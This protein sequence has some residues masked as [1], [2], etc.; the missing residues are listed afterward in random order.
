MRNNNKVAV[1]EAVF[2][3]KRF[4]GVDVLLGPEMKSTGEVMGL[5]NNFGH[6]FA[7]SQTAT[8]TSIPLEG[9][10]FISVK[11]KDKKLISEICIRLIKFGYKIVCTKGTGEFLK[12]L[13]LNVTVVNKVREGRPHIVDL[14]KNNKIGMIFN[15]TEGSKSISD[16]F[17][18]REAALLSNIPYYTTIS[19][20]NAVILAIKKLKSSK[21]SIKSLQSY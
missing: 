13:G 4:K 9:N 6:A 10:V 1:K 12:L 21:S 17:S 14:I 3:F 15:T 11:D 19:G 5:D 16:S 20:C 7:K 18:L 2:P 8:G